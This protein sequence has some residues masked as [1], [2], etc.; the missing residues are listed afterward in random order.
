[1]EKVI[2][3]YKETIIGLKEEIA[4][5]TEL[6][7]CAAANISLLVKEQGG[8]QKISKAAVAEALGKYRLCAVQDNEGNYVLSLTEEGKK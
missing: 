7:D 6:L 8:T 2:A 1:M 3:S 4:A 5:L